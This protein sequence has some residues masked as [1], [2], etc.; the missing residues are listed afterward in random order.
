MRV[1][2]PPSAVLMMKLMLCSLRNSRFNADRN[3]PR[4]TPPTAPSCAIIS[5]GTYI[6]RRQQES[7]YYDN[8][9]NHHHTFWPSWE[10]WMALMIWSSFLTASPR[11]L[12][13]FWRHSVSM[14]DSL[15]H[16]CQAPNLCK[17]LVWMC[18]ART[19]DSPPR[20]RMSAGSVSTSWCCCLRSKMDFLE[21]ACFHKSLPK[22]R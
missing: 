17:T 1:S 8:N 16:G 15:I 9:M 7:Q 20:R 19:L 14:L 5:L 21:V 6:T 13:I 18:W 3:P 2:F 11:C 4:N 22:N 10:Y 12:S